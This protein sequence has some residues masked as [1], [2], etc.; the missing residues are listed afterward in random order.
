MVFFRFFFRAPFAV[1]ASGA[2]VAPPVGASEV[3]SQGL[4]CSVPS[5]P[6]KGTNTRTFRQ[7]TCDLKKSTKADLLDLV[8]VGDAMSGCPVSTESRL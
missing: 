1:G 8:L 6:L 3:L 5:T 7:V 2:R 4:L